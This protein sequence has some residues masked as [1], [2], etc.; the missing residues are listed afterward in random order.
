MSFLKKLFS[1]GSASAQSDLLTFTV[2]CARCGETIEGR[3]NPTTDLSTNDDSTGYFVR[4][5]VMGSGRCFQRIEVEM[6][7]DA[8]RKLLEKQIHGGT[9]VE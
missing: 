5:V 3:I 2:K 4:K 1:G 7:F 9:F 6:Q 8:N